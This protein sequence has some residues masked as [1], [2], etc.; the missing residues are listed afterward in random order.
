MSFILHKFL[1]RNSDRMAEWLRRWPTNPMCNACVGSNPTSVVRFLTEKIYIYIIDNF[2]YYYLKMFYFSY[3]DNLD[4]KDLDCLLM[5]N[6]QV[7]LVTYHMPLPLMNNPWLSFD[8]F[9]FLSLL[10]T[11][12]ILLY[13]LFYFQFFTRCRKKSY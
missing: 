3:S 4:H 13:K 8:N 12:I 1:V 5:L 7:V 2:T 9:D 6:H 11:I 10:I